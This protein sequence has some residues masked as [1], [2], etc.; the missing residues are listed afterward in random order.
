M[1]E[2]PIVTGSATSLSWRLW[3]VAAPS[4]LSCQIL[5]PETGLWGGAW[6]ARKAMTQDQH[7]V[8][9]SWDAGL[10]FRAMNGTI[11]YEPLHG[12]LHRHGS[13]THSHPHAGPHTHKPEPGHQH[14]HDGEGHG[15]SHGLID[16]TIKRSHEGIRA[17]ALSLLVLGLAAA[18]QTAIFALTSSVAL[19]ADLIHNFGDAATA[20]PLA[21][22]FALRSVRVER[23]AGLAVVFAIAVSAAVAGF[24]AIERL[25][26]PQDVTHLGALAA[27]GGIGYAGNRIAAEIRTRA[28][29][30][31]NSPALV[32]DGNHARADAYISLAVIA[33]ALAVA[34]GAQVL[35]PLIGLGIT[36]VILRITWQSWQTVRAYDGHEHS[37]VS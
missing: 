8:R 14:H 12:E 26:N 30:R 24:E 16:P 15:H 11:A 25:I 34:L 2:A 21:A 18:A 4:R 17:V 28:G 20:F 7:L 3:R 32:A 6:F 31:L 33:S 13:L 1:I 9:P 22:A 23:W 5:Q 37:H 29:D 35:D 36:V 10:A 19:L 27:A